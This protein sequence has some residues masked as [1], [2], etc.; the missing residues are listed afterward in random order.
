MKSK[1]SEGAGHMVG[2]IEAGLH[3][4]DGELRVQCPY[5][6]CTTCVVAAACICDAK[7]GWERETCMRGKSVGLRSEEGSA[8]LYHS[9]AF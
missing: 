8:W 2:R 7:E 9:A 6:P 5:L 3:D 1:G 4:T